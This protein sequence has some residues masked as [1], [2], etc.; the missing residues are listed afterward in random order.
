[1]GR[2]RQP[3]G[4]VRPR[5]GGDDARGRRASRAPTRAPAQPAPTYAPPP[6][7]A[8]PAASRGD[9]APY[10]RRPGPDASAGTSTPAMPPS[11]PDVPP[12]DARF[13]FRS[14]GPGLPLSDSPPP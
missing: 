9:F 6:P 7:D 5:L 11:T 2:R 3:R 12:V 1:M 8:P 13:L 14:I 10:E 4:R